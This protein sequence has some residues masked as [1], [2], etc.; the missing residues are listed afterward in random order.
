M[1]GQSAGAG[2]IQFMMSSK[3]ARG[4]FARAIA[5]SSN[6]IDSQ[7]FPYPFLSESEKKGVAFAKRLG[8]PDRGSIAF[9]RKLSTAELLGAYAARRLRRP[10][11][12]S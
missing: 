4:L 10:S 8:A 9:L 11:P 12:R 3:V 7:F 5:E 2:D 6:V 1:F